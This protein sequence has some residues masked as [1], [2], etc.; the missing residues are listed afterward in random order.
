MGVKR[1]GKRRV[2]AR[3]RPASSTARPARKAARRPAAARRTARQRPFA[4]GLPVRPSF[5]L[6]GL[7][8]ALLLWQ[9]WA[10]AG[11]DSLTR[12]LSARTAGTSGVLLLVAGLVVMGLEAAGL[13]EPSGPRSRA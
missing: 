12:W 7:A 6:L 4:A 10:P 9:L 5:V 8:A 3:R 13:R 11:G 2:T 1:T